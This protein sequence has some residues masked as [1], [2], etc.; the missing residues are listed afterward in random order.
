MKSFFSTFY[1]KYSSIN[2]NP[3]VFFD[4]S[5]GGINKG[6][7]TFELFKDI[8]PKTSENFRAL[9]TGEKGK[10]ISKKALHYK[11]SIFNRVIPGFMC[12]GGD[13]TLGNG[14]GGESIYS[15]QFD[16]ENF[17]MNHNKPFVLSMANR[18]P[19]TNSSQ[20]FITFVP[21]PHLNYKHVVFGKVIEGFNVLKLIEDEGSMSGQTSQTIKIE[22]SGEIILE[23]QKI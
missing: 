18:G 5:I 13:I 22:N 3:F 15:K 17:K 8:T 2:R 9:C 21:C 11:G 1:R 6:K 10:G 14:R 16:D 20:F 7:I 4:I 19:N 23:N 12:Q